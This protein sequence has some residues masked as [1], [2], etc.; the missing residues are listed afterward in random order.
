MKTTRILSIL[1]IAII[2]SCSDETTVFEDPENDL[3]LETS[4]NVLESSVQYDKAGVLDIFEEDEITGKSNR[5][6]KD[7]PVGDYP[8]TLIAQV[9]V[10][11]F[12]GGENLTA[13]HV[14]ISGD[15]AYV[16]YNTVDATYAGGVDIV[17]VS[18]PA[19]PIVTSRLYYQGVD[20][21]SVAYDNGYVYLAGGT[22]SETNTAP[23]NSLVA[24]IQVTGNG[25]FDFNAGIEYGFQ[26][27]FTATDVAVN[28]NLVFL[29][30]GAQG[31]VGV[32][33]TLGL[34]P[35]VD[36]P[37]D[38]L[39]SVAIKDNNIAVLD[40]SEGIR[41]LSSA[42]EPI[43]NITLDSDFG[44]GEKRT[45][46][47]FE[48]N[49][50]VSEGNK[51]AGVYNA[52]T[53]TFLE[54]VSI[55]LDPENVAEGDIVTNAVAVNE[56]VLL[57][58]N[59]GAGLSLSDELATATNV[60]GVVQLEGSINYVASKGD[61]IFA[62][63]GKEGLQI[64]KLNRPSNSLAAR[65]EETSTYK[66]S[67]NLNVNSNDVFAY[68][69]GQRGK[70]LASANIGGE[71]LL[72]G[73]WSVI[74]SVNL[75]ANGMLD[76]NGSFAIGSNIRRGGSNTTSILNINSGAKLR[77]EGKLTV[78]GDLTLNDGATLEFLGEDSEI[79]VHGR[80]FRN[81]NTTVEG[82]F[83]DKKNKF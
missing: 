47:F 80:V 51:G 72:C 49:I 11:S 67:R 35:I 21:N 24:K 74:R 39:R 57:M 13:S 18:D 15:Y 37:F 41:F 71:A 68:N 12:R 53:G 48:N 55:L 29:T 2:F 69:S 32:Y 42:L 6:E 7:A 16:S 22:D 17:D 3:S 59:G 43:S 52:S 34:T 40:A 19:N 75:N 61:F 36:L 62:A 66:G 1:C 81:G 76:I 38:D 8:L 5:D 73:S 83:I 82:T 77:V 9:E 63:S 20:V 33:S 70:R 14:A 10:P 50:V 58:A 45:L 27:G 65:C 78:Y 28:G 56:D 79:D 46:D 23:F 25:K 4:P 64:I 31:A 26:N 30:S 54:H 44:A 60:V